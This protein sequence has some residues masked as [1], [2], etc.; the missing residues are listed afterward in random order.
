M[1]GGWGGGNL[2]TMYQPLLTRPNLDTP[3]S[4]P[5]AHTTLNIHRDV[6]ELKPV[7][8]SIDEIMQALYMALDQYNYNLR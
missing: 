5:S 1:G 3:D 7:L 2:K 8:D 4:S 6:L